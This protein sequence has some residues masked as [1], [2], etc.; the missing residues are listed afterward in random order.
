MKAVVSCLV[1]VTLWSV[2]TADAAPVSCIVAR[3]AVQPVTAGSCSIAIEDPRA[4]WITEWPI[5]TTG[6]F[7]I[8]IRGNN[9]LLS[10]WSCSLSSSGAS[11]GGGGGDS[12]WM[13]CAGG[14]V[15]SA[16]VMQAH[17]GWVCLLIPVSVS[18]TVLPGDDGAPF[19]GLIQ[20]SAYGSDL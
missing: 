10:S 3:N 9:R 14:G 2:R 18:F 4:D 6:R 20:F 8:D 17:R 19:Q 1:V 7:R 11:C 5:G 12:S 16:A 15:L 13:Y